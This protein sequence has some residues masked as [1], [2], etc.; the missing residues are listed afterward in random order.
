MRMRTVFSPAFW[1]VFGAQTQSHVAKIKMA[2]G[3]ELCDYELQRLERIKENR[4]MLEELF[5]DGTSM[6]MPR[7]IKK[8][9]PIGPRR[10]SQQDSQGGSGSG[11]ST[12]E[13][14]NSPHKKSSRYSVRYIKACGKSY[15]SIKLIFCMC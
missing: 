14:G 10:V 12:P 5:P 13:E 7:P 2:E 3:G 8:R 1:R 4:K 11:G 6:Y 9:K 15:A